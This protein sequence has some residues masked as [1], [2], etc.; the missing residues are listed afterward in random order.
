[1]FTS[2]LIWS[3][4]TGTGKSFIGEV[5]QHVYG[6]ANSS[7]IDSDDLHDNSN[8]WIAGKQF[9]HADEVALSAT[10]SDMGVLKSMITGKHV[11]VKI[12]YVPVYSLPNVA[13]FF[14]TSNQPD[15]IRLE[16]EDRRFFVSKLDL[17]KPEAWW[18]KLDRW[19]RR[20]GGAAAWR[21]YLE[22]RVDCSKF[23][24]HGRAPE[25]VAKAEM[26]VETM[27]SLDRACYEFLQDPDGYMG[28]DHKLV[29][30]RDVATAEQFATFLTMGKGAHHFEENSKYGRPS[31]N[32]I[33]RAMQKAGAVKPSFGPLRTEEGMRRLLAFRNL[34]KWKAHIGNHN[35]WRENFEKRAVRASGGDT[36]VVEIG[37]KRGAKT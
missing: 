19:L 30:G 12:K 29:R 7:F 17:E 37:K 36:K 33:S 32:M 35:S 16:L 27:S 24:P 1:M 10:R 11:R 20:E 34:D 13:N 3:V 15:A 5:M 21:H 14:F 8:D 18:N 6:E 28:V 22:E 31:L 4:K 9:V 25:T 2:A 26:Q 23:N